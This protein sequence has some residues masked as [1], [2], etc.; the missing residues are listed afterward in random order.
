[1]Q[2]AGEIQLSR[3]SIR[4]GQVIYVY[5]CY[6]Y[7]YQ[8]LGNAHFTYVTLCNLYNPISTLLLFPFYM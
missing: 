1:M 2:I 5:I 4:Y 7:A 8:A 6:S 3:L